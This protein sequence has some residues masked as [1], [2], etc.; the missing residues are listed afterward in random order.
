MKLVWFLTTNSILESFTR[1]KTIPEAPE[2]WQT[3]Y[4]PIIKSDVLPVG[5]EIEPKVTVGADGSLVS[6][7]S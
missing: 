7:D 5:P 1:A 6:I 3:N 2:L 4:S